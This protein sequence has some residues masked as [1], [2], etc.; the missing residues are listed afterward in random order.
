[1]DAN[2]LAHGDFASNCLKDDFLVV[3]LALFVRSRTTRKQVM[4]E[5]VMQ[6]ISWKI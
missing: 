1:M 6:E 5:V 2:L 4:E 3:V